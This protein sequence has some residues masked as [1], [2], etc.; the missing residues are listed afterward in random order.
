MRRAV[1]PGRAARPAA[2]HHPARR[3]EQHGKDHLPGLLQHSAPGVLPARHRPLPGLQRATVRH[4]RVPRHRPD[5]TRFRRPQRRVQDRSGRGPRLRQRHA[6]VH[7]V[8]HLPRTRLATGHL[9]LPVPVRRRFV[10]GAAE[11][12]RRDHLENPRTRRGD[13]SPLPP[14]GLH[15]RLA[16]RHA[17]RRQAGSGRA[18][19]HA[20]RRPLYSRPDY[21]ARRGRA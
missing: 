21:T 13:A 7:T 11:K 4:G 12:R 14:R 20:T 10:S 3:R 8:R 6:A 19:G 1:L 2:A 18:S 16:A 17:R 9:V 15:A 5:E